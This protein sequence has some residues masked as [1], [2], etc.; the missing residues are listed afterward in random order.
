MRPSVG[1]FSN[2]ADDETDRLQ[3]FAYVDSSIAGS[4]KC[5]IVRQGLR[6]NASARAAM[7]PISAVLHRCL[8]RWWR[9]LDP[10]YPS[11]KSACRDH[12]RATRWVVRRDSV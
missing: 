11:N 7:V 10:R 4:S 8:E 5:W 1:R 6:Q 9:T 12:E 3:I 2:A